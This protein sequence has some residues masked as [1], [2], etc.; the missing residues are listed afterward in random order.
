MIDPC[1]T[2]DITVGM[3]TAAIFGSVGMLFMLLGIF[4]GPMLWH[5]MRGLFR[6]PQLLKPRDPPTYKVTSITTM[7]E[8]DEEYFERSIRAASQVGTEWPPKRQ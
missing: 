5:G 4:V 3:L 6:D 1:G 7:P 2:S 8:S